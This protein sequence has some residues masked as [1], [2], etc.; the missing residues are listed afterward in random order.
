[1]FIFAHGRDADKHANLN[2][3]VSFTRPLLL[4]QY[5]G[6]SYLGKTKAHVRGIISYFSYSSRKF[7]RR[8]RFLGA[9]DCFDAP[10]RT[11][12]HF[13]RRLTAYQTS[14]RGSRSADEDNRW[15]YYAVRGYR[16]SGRKQR[17]TACRVA[18]VQLMSASAPLSA[19]VAVAALMTLPG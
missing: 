8:T 7:R 6:S 12:A 2:P 1:V 17:H 5:A 9:V 19:R 16:R 11:A 10:Y 13:L 15:R 3:V 4:V 14:R 18:S